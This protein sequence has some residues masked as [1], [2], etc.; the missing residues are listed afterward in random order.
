MMEYK[1]TRNDLLK[2]VRVKRLVEYG[3]SV[4]RKKTVLLTAT[5]LSTFLNYERDIDNENAIISIAMKRIKFAI[6]FDGVQSVLSASN[7]IINNLS[8]NFKTENLIGTFIPS[9]LLKDMVVKRDYG[10]LSTSIR[11]EE[12]SSKFE[13]LFRELIIDVNLYIRIRKLS[14]AISRTKGR[15][16][17]LNKKLLPSLNLQE[18]LISEFLENAERQELFNTRKLLE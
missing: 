1:R 11:L 9:L 6:A 7:L 14:A 13:Q 8:L 10:E 17:A 2:L 5:L 3:K 16:N 18:R 15:Y 4:L 12:A